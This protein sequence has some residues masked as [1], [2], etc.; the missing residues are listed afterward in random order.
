M[1]ICGSFI[2]KAHL[3]GSSWTA[4]AFGYSYVN[5]NLHV[6]EFAHEAGSKLY[7]LRCSS[8]KMKQTPPDVVS[9]TLPQLRLHCM[10]SGSASHSVQQV[11]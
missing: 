7:H 9:V 6:M 2:T 3:S 5:F 4:N 8:R 1:Y 11:Q 10:P